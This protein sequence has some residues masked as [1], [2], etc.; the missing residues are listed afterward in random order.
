MARKMNPA[1]AKM[2]M[3][4]LKPS[5]KL[6]AVIGKAAISRPQA[7]KKLWV[8]FKKHKLQD[9]KNRRNI[10]ADA[11]LKP[12]FGKAQITMFEVGKILNKHLSK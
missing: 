6:A 9:K 4:K 11:A 1:F 8:Y 12:V 5:D 7:V 3:M 10:N 2:A